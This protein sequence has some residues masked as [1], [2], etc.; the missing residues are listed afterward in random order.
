MSPE[1]LWNQFKRIFGYLSNKVIQYKSIRNDKRSI[2]IFMQDGT[3]YIFTYPPNGHYTL[4]TENVGK[5]LKGEFDKW[6]TLN[7][8]V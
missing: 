4:V 3:V 6:K 2:R 7:P 5:D 8:V 1:A